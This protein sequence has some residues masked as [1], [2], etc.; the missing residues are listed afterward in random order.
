MDAIALLKRDHAEVKELFEQVESLSERATASRG[1]LCE[2]ITRA[3]ELHTKIEEGIFYPSFRS[4]AEESEEREKILEAFEEH[5]VAKMLIGELQTMDPADETFQPKLMVLME[6]VR[7][8]IKEEEG[9]IFKMA[10]DLFDR[11]ELAQMGEQIETAKA[12][13]GAPVRARRGE[14]EPRTRRTARR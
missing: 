3:L 9:K 5:A 1:K 11:D 14:I 13:G 8:H 10:R 4:R 12:E 2:K 6:S 7:H